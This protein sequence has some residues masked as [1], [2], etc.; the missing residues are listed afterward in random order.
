MKQSWHEPRTWSRGIDIR[1]KKEK[2]WRKTIN[3]GRFR[4]NYPEITPKR[5]EIIPK[6]HIFA[7]KALEHVLYGTWRAVKLVLSPFVARGVCICRCCRVSRVCIAWGWGPRTFDARYLVQFF[8]LGGKQ[9]LSWVQVQFVRIRRVFR[10]RMVQ[11]SDKNC[12]PNAS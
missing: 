11:K 7:P 9:K 8:C 4:K 12:T 5:H 3:N 2:K 10:N 1:C 6:Q